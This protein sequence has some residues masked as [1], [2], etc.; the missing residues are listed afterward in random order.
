M[1]TKEVERYRNEMLTYF[2]ARPVD[3]KENQTQQ[4]YVTPLAGKIYE[5]NDRINEP[6]EPIGQPADANDAEA[7]KAK[8]LVKRRSRTN[9]R[10]RGN[11]LIPEEKPPEPLRTFLTEEIVR[12]T[13]EL[14][15]EVENIPF[16]Q[17]F[18]VSTD[19]VQSVAFQ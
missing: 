19:L 16:S 9:V 15:D 11:S 7:A 14:N 13:P 1:I 17:S 5:L 6:F 2:R 10:S 18:Q 8:A 12:P 3:Q 4:Y